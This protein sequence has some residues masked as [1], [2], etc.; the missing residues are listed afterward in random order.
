MSTL[1]LGYDHGVVKNVTYYHHS[2][3]PNDHQ[4]QKNKHRAPTERAPA[5]CSPS[6]QSSAQPEPVRV[7]GVDSVRN[8]TETNRGLEAAGQRGRVVA[9]AS[10]AKQPLRE[11][12]VPAAATATAIE[13]TRAAADGG[14]AVRG[15]HSVALV[16]RAREFAARPGVR[17]RLLGSRR[18]ARHAETAQHPGSLPIPARS[19]QRPRQTAAT[20]SSDETDAQSYARIRA[21]AAAA[22]A[23]VGVGMGPSPMPSQRR[24]RPW[25]RKPPRQGITRR[26]EEPADVSVVL[27]ATRVSVQPAAGCLARPDRPCRP[28]AVLPLP[29]DPNAPQT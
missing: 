10:F 4:H 27:F 8:G 24:S 18:F 16:R 3:Q 20:P 15:P 11:S 29:G 25:E 9:V 6:R 22:S 2:L 12:S 21:K 19:A 7:H 17:R 13:P 26:H 23:L 14:I 28:K 1:Y 5:G